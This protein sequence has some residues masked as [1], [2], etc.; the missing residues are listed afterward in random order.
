M[1]ANG[2]VQATPQLEDGMDGRP[3]LD[4]RSGYVKRALPTLPQQGKRAPWRLYQNYIRDILML[5]FG[6]VN[7]RV[8]KFRRAEKTNA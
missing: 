5:R 3:V 8:M 1:E 2:Y 4:F 7:H 6:K